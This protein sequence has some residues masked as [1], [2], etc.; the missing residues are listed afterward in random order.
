MEIYKCNFKNSNATN[1]DLNSWIYIRGGTFILAN[2]SV[3]LIPYEKQS[4]IIICQQINRSAGPGSCQIGYPANRQIGQGWSASSQAKYGNPVVAMDGVGAVL[5]PVYFWGNTGQGASVPEPFAI[6]AQ[7]QSSGA[8]AVKL[9]EF[10]H[11]LG[12]VFCFR[13]MVIRLG[14]GWDEF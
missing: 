6:E 14:H 3:D 1:L 12:A 10:A 2:C 7:A 4:F 9:M 11:R 5:D 13:P 8:V